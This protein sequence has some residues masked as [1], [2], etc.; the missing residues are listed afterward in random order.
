MRIKKT[1]QKNGRISISITS[2][3][4]QDGRSKMRTV[5][6]YG[7]LDELDRIHGDGLAFVQSEL[8]QMNAEAALRDSPLDITIHPKEK[9]NKKDAS[10]KNIGSAIPLMYYNALGIEK[11]LRNKTR[12]NALHYDINAVMRLLTIDHILFPGSKLASWRGRD[13]YFFRSDFSDDDLYR[14]LDHIAGAKDTVI[15]AMNKAIDETIGREV[16]NV[17]YDVTNYYFEIDEE[18]DLRKKGVG[19]DHKPK[20]L[21]AMGLLQDSRS[22]PITYEIFEGN[23]PDS[24]TMIDVLSKV[25]EDFKLGHLILVADKG[26][27]SSSNIAALVGS[28]NGFIFSQSIRGTKSTD[29]LRDWVARVLA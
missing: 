10:V 16:S 1:K 12:N 27:N 2:A 5:K 18:D 20:P 22:I 13:G 15:K 21:V 11:A 23:T 14:A 9:I 6:G 19:K 7:Y 3:Y 8:E 4:W 25:K 28:G 26:I 24:L 29:A 17:Y